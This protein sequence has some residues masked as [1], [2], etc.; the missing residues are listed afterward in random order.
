MPPPATIKGY[1]GTDAAMEAKIKREHFMRSNKRE[2]LGLGAYFFADGISADG[3]VKD[4]IKWAEVRA[5]CF[6][7]TWRYWAVLTVDIK[8]EKMVDLT[9]ENSMKSFNRM[10]DIV[11]RKFSLLPARAQTSNETDS[12][13]DRIID[14]EILDH[15]REQTEVCAV[16]AHFFFKFTLE[17]RNSIGSRLPN[18]TIVCVYEPEKAIERTSIQTHSQGQIK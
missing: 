18:V 13:N 10:R 3:P 5:K 9:D 14:V 16:K 1:H 6:R 15:I 17:N 11:Y 7:A 4:S 8:T 12:N 2:W